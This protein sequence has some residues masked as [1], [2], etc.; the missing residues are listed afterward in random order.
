[1]LNTMWGWLPG[2]RRKIL[3]AR[4]KNYKGGYLEREK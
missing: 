1:M 2:G 3:V 4:G